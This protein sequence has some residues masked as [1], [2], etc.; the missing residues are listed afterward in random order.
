VQAAV[1][2]GAGGVDSQ[3]SRALTELVLP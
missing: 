3:K 2:R 1:S